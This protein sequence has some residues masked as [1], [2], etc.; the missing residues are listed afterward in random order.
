LAPVALTSVAVYQRTIAASLERI[1]E[2]VLDWEHLPGLHR[3]SFDAI[4]CLE[5][6]E[7]G[8]RARLRGRGAAAGDEIEVE[9]RLDRANLRYV[10]ATTAGAGAGSEI[11]T[12]LAP[13][14]PH[15]TDI[16]VE[17]KLPGV[18]SAQVEALGRGYTA[19]YTRL[20]DEDES[21]MVRREAMLAR[22]AA[23]P[24][25]GRET[26]ELGPLDALR[27]RLPLRVELDGRPFRVLALGDAL[28]AHS[29]VCPHLLGPLE[30]A[31]PDGDTL[32]CPWHRYRFD[33]R[34]GRSCDGR[35]LRLMPAPR[36]VIGP[37]DRVTLVPT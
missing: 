16:R 25:R 15:A 22:V 24:E 20:W 7:Q 17:F 6:S 31:V 12:E 26:L 14:H 36:V 2:N 3:G 30:D 32:E 9:V 1:W 13:L 33:L 18:V 28:V 23:L 35:A 4:R 29:T 27:A 19:L 8:W 21:M 11:W 37:D 5:A 10:T 34:S